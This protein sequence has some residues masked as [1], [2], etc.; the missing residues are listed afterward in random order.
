MLQPYIGEL[1]IDKI[2]IV[3]CMQEFAFLERNSDS[4]EILNN[5]DV[6]ILQRVLKQYFKNIR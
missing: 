3:V 2:P 1:K 4:E 6:A 5:L